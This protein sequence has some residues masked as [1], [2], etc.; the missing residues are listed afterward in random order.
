MTNEPE[1][2]DRVKRL[3]LCYYLCRPR[4]KNECVLFV[5]VGTGHALSVWYRNPSSIPYR[6]PLS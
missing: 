3:S 1:S 2:M 6:E 5:P 4:K